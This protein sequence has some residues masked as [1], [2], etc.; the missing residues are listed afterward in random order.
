MNA[1]FPHPESRI[2]ELI[3]RLGHADRLERV[4][5]AVDLVRL[6]RRGHPLVEPL[7]AALKDKRPVVR[8][9][10]ALVLGDLASEVCD[11]APALA[12]AL[13]DVDEGVRRRAAVALSQFG[14]AAA[15]AVPALRIALLDPDEGVRSFAAAAL[16][17]IEPKG[18]RAQAA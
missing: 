5:A 8:K 17:M 18:A 16:V 15:A 10:A 12:V 4:H 7:S 14:P 2:P 11:A 13:C 1:S 3:E 6:G 9:M